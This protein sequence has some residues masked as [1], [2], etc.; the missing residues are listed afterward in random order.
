MAG[1]FSARVA[2]ALVCA[3]TLSLTACGNSTTTSPSPTPAD[4]TSTE[5][6]STTVTVG[7]AIF[8]SFSI[9]QYGNVAVTLTGVTGT[10]LPDGLTLG[11]GIG[12]PS[13]TSCATSNTV[14]AA[15]GDTAQLTGAYGPG[16][17][18]VRVYDTGTLTGPVAITASVAHP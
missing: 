4:P 2:L 5:S 8:Y 9:A 15:P 12:Q 16:V 18:C 7:G 10:D 11:L 6:F 14:S 3:G 13:G 1:M 17:F